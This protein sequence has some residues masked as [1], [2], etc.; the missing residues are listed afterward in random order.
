MTRDS[1]QH[2]RPFQLAS[3]PDSDEWRT[4]AALGIF[5]KP[6]GMAKSQMNR[7]RR[8]ITKQG[9]TTQ[10]PTKTSLAGHV[11][12]LAK[13]SNETGHL[14]G[15]KAYE[16]YAQRGREEGH[17]LEDWLAAEAIVHGTTD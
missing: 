7:L 12:L 1:Q 8:L 9:V 6:H 14:I 5:L 11:P 13:T 17:A 3:T 16:L 4:G 2:P 10:S 15:M